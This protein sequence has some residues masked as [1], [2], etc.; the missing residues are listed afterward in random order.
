MS[1]P[2]LSL[3]TEKALKTFI[4]AQNLFNPAIDIHA[5]HETDLADEGNY[6]AIICSLPD[7]YS[8]GGYNAILNLTFKVATQVNDSTMRAVQIQAHADRSGAVIDLLCEQRFNAIKNAL[9]ISAVPVHLEFDTWEQTEHSE[10]R[11]EVQLV[12]ELRY[13]FW[14][15][16]TF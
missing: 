4:L 6:L 5:A 8:L 13:E 11:T 10:S 14:V 2:S 16:L 15:H 1:S 3:D 12:S 7:W 9:N